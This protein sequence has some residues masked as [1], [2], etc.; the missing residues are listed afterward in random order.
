MK[1]LEFEGTVHVQRFVLGIVCGLLPILCVLFGL[2]SCTWGGDS[3]SVL[4]SVSETY[5]SQH[6]II[7]I[8]A[9]GLCTFFFGTYQGY[10]GWDKFFTVLA[11]V[12]SI[13]VAAFPCLHPVASIRNTIVYQGL[14]SVPSGICNIIHSISAIMVFG[15]F[16]LMTLTQFT[17]GNDKKR[18]ICY[19]IC[20]GLILGAML[21]LMLTVVGWLPYFKYSTMVYEFIML[22]AFA[23][24]WIVKSKVKFKSNTTK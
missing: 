12:G 6:K 7:M 13:G 23:V 18:N 22:E 24:A 2:F 3:W 8:I 10:D 4:Y 17:K 20:G 16:G 9:L 5:W 11:A 1:K 15:S 21:A 14:F 19:Y